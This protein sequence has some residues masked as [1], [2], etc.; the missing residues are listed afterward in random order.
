MPVFTQVSLIIFVYI[1][2]YQWL[3]VSTRVTEVYRVLTKVN[4]LFFFGGPRIE[5]QLQLYLIHTFFYSQ[6]AMARSIEYPES[7]I[8]NSG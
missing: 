1:D 7:W 8:Q 5:K 2:F 3:H 4:K 6:A